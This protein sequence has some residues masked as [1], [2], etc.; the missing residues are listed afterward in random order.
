MAPKRTA[1]GEPVEESLIGRAG[2]QRGTPA[3]QAPLASLLG[4][5]QHGSSCAPKAK[6]L[7]ER[8]SG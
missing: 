6:R 5:R 1:A 2:H 7:I 3:R 8:T 4:I